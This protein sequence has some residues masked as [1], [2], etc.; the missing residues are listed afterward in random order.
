MG[1]LALIQH[2]YFY[3]PEKSPGSSGASA[4]IHALILG[5]DLD[6]RGRGAW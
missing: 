3:R 6:A 5:S 4:Y 1:L 2:T